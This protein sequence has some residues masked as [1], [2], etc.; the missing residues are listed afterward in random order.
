MLID[1]GLN[2]T[3][4]QF[5]RDRDAVVERA[6]AA[7]VE[8]MVLTGTS[9]QCSR[10]A[11]GLAQ[12]RPGV[13]YSTAGVHPHHA[14]DVRPE[15]YAEIRTLAARPEV[16]AVGECG[17][18]HNRNYSPQDVQAEVFEAQL[19]L[20]VEVNLPVFLHERDAHGPFLEILAPYLPRLPGAV[21]HCFTGN[22]AAL[23]AYLAAGCH[24]GVTGW[25]CDERRG[26]ELRE[27]VR[28]VPID[29]L[30]LETDAPYLLPRDLRPRPKSRRNE[31]HWLGHIAR[32]V[33]ACRGEPVDAVIAGTARTTAAFFGL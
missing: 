28:E 24:I 11:S 26:G 6:L 14:K 32:V 20:A 27:L 8:Q 7:G 25:V 15:D 12:A 23:R 10:D 2:L 3:S 33:A 1:I 4:K 9:L 31:P 5:D 30:M 22:R 19:G 16:V 29:R 18:D 21:V 17:L 13:L